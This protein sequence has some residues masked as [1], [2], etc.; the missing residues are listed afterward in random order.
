MIT[1]AQL[2]SLLVEWFQSAE[3]PVRTLIRER[4][5]EGAVLTFGIVSEC[6]WW[7]IFEPALRVHD[8][9]VI[10]RCLRVAERLLDEG[11]QVIQDALVVRVLDY[12]SD[13]S[14]QEVVRLYSGPKA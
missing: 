3:E 4:P 9:D 12:L 7:G 11:D 1:F 6:F 14:W 13:P 8:V 10:V 2:P 5:G